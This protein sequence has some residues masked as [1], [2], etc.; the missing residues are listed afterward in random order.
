MVESRNMWFTK[1]K[2]DS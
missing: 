2:R 1:S